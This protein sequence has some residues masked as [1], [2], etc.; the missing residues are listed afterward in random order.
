LF[1]LIKLK[2][3]RDN[4]WLQVHGTNVFKQAGQPGI[5]I[6]LN[7]L[8][9][10]WDD[11][12]TYSQRVRNYTGKPIDLEIRRSFDGHVVFHSALKPTLHDYRTIE[13][14]SSVDAGKTSDLYFA[15]LRH[16]GRNSKQNNVTIQDGD[17]HP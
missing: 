12:E 6:E 14:T 16:Q 1:D 10:G 4:I 7:S 2:S 9:A 5:Q 15:V 17:I 8:V 11:H 13:F 3:Y